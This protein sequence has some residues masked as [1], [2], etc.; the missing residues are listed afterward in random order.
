MENI[1][2]VIGAEAPALSKQDRMAMQLLSVTI[3]AA[4]TCTFFSYV[5]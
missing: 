3:L 5:N 1:S 4:K 2:L